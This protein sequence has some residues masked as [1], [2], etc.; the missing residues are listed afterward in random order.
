M[1]STP[2]E[3]GATESPDVLIVGS[4]MAGL[5]MAVKLLAAGQR[6]FVILEKA[7]S[8]GG[9]WRENTYPGCACDV[10]SVMYSY[11]FA[12][13]R[14]WSRMYAGQPEILDYIRRVVKDHDLEPFVRFNTEAVSYEFDEAADRWHVRTR[15][16][17]EFRPRIVVLAHGA[18]HLPNRPDFPGMERFGGAVFHSAQWDH[19]VD[20]KGKRVAVIGTG[21]SAAQFIPEIVGQA[22]HVDVFQRNAHW[23]LPKAD[24]PLSDRERK[25]FRLAPFVQRLYRLAAYWTHELPVLAFLHPRF[26]K[27]LEIAAR[28]TLDK[29][30]ADPVLR[31]KLTPSYQIGCKRILLTNDYFPAMQQPNVDLV[32]S[33]VAEFTKTGIRDSD[34][35]LHRADVVIL[36]T[37]FS[38]DNRC[39][40]EHIVGRGGET[41]QHAW[42]DGMTAY[43]G[44]TVSGFPNMFMVMGPN[45]GGGA[46][47][48]L[49]VIEAQLHYIVECLRLMK[50]RGATRLDVRAEVQRKFNSWLHGKLSRSV[51][52]T[53]GC[54]S[55]F[56][57]HTGANRQSWPGTGTSYWRATRRPDPDAYALTAVP[58]AVPA[59]L[60]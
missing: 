47:S 7:D 14:N 34:G 35:E 29:Q 22:A 48:I 23:V 10:A 16:G 31:A 18:L 25:A 21:A 17:E 46:Q 27:I 50:T 42:R 20:L 57:D 51:W 38:T 52:N 49:F 43:L 32:T 1:A 54:H 56:L 30:V 58:R 33:G 60:P 11:S 4:G 13:N 28:R 59:P 45:S 39:A 8:V 55:W 5:G 24:R 53:G 44:M 37:G 6:D 15:S 26:V 36:G 2:N 3:A 41:I 9:T 40:H 19:S 12:P